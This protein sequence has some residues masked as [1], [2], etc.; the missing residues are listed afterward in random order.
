MQFPH[1]TEVAGTW[2]GPGM[3]RC[4]PPLREVCSRVDTGINQEWGLLTV[5]DRI[6]SPEDVRRLSRDEHVGETRQGRDA[7]VPSLTLACRAVDHAAAAGQFVAMAR[8][9]ARARASSA[10]QT[11]TRCCTT[12]T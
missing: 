3:C 1:G 8:R 2:P 4:D 6:D 7:F 11:T 10:R 9:A 12:R 5:L